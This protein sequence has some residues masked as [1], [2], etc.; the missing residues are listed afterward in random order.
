[1]LPGN[2]NNMFENPKQSVRGDS[3]RDC[4]SIPDGSIAES[5]DTAPACEVV[6]L[7]VHYMR[8]YE[9]KCNMA[10]SINGEMRRNS[11][12]RETRVVCLGSSARAY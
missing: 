1:M 5:A 8:Q 4:C 11:V 6:A 3:R 12:Q 9:M 10:K 7:G 2:A